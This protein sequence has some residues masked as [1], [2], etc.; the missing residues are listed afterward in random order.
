MNEVRILKVI[1]LLCL[2]V[3]VGFIVWA[4]RPTY[5]TVEVDPSFNLPDNLINYTTRNMGT[6]VPS[7][8][9]AEFTIIL[10]AASGGNV[11]AG[12]ELSIS[13]T[14]TAPSSLAWHV[15]SIY[16]NLDSALIYPLSTDPTTLGPLFAYV[17]LY[18]ASN[19]YRW[20]GTQTIIYSQ[21][22]S[23]GATVI[24]IRNDTHTATQNY[25]TFDQ[26][27]GP[28]IQIA[29]PDTII[30]EQNQGLTLG[31]TCFI[32]AFAALDLRF[33]TNRSLSVDRPKATTSKD[34]QEKAAGAVQPVVPQK[35]LKTQPPARKSRRKQ[36]RSKN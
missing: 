32:L 8:H 7:R 26:A 29:S 10:T 9:D 27:I 4:F 24:F 16:L 3:G 35:A 18:Q 36:S 13:I 15:I 20:S 22:G 25:G 34:G 2:V 33:K 17:N 1:A 31:L 14:M 30:A 28:I 12:Q 19:H 11:V 6:L 5:K 21:A 23:F